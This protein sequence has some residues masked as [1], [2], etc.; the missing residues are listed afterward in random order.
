MAEEREIECLDVRMNESHS[1]FRLFLPS[2]DLRNAIW[3]HQRLMC[4][5]RGQFVSTWVSYFSLCFFFFLFSYFEWKFGTVAVAEGEEETTATT[6]K[7]NRWM[8]EWKYERKARIIKCNNNNRCWPR[9]GRKAGVGVPRRLRF[10]SHLIDW[11]LQI[12]V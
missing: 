8:D 12:M 11:R 3:R 1:H 10:G 4:L 2:S 5:R 9:W 6:K 7:P